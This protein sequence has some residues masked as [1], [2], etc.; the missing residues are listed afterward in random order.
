[1]AEIDAAIK[2]DQE[3]D[4]H[5]KA[6]INK[7]I[8]IWTAIVPETV[9]QWTSMLELW[10]R[11]DPGAPI[12][13]SMNTPGG[14]V[15]QGFALY[16]TIKRM[17]RKGHHFTIRGT[18]QVASM[19]SVIFQA[20]DC[21]ILDKNATFMIH[22]ISIGGLEGKLSDIEEDAAHMKTLN[23]RLLSILAEKSNLT[24]REITRKSKK[25]E[26]YLSAEQALEYGFA[27]TVE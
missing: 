2:R 1:M 27:D 15:T 21:R 4:R 9:A 23:E 3:K 14:H 25:K 22:E 18:G 8:D 17:Q 5:A 12:T 16:D 20:G 6:G 13:V 11:R 10:E 19:G 7:H 24:A 26:W